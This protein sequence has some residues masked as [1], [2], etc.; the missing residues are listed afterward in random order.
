MQF[1]SNDTYNTKN[2]LSNKNLFLNRLKSP[3]KKYKRYLGSP[4]RYG[5]GKTLAVG[6]ILEYLPADIKKVVSPFFG[7]GSVEIAIAKELEVEV[8]GY[9]IFEIL[10]NYWQIQISHPE[11]LYQELLKIKPTSENYE[12]IKSILKQHWNKLDGYD[13]KLDDL[14]CA[15]YYFFNHNLSYGPGFLGWMSSIYREEKKYLA[16]IEKV[17]NFDVKNLNV[18]CNKFEETIPKHTQDFLYLDPP[19]FLA[20]DSKM[21]R[22]IYPMRNFPIHHNGFNH[23]LLS[24]LLHEHKGGFILSYNDCSWVRERYKN[25][26]IIEVSWQY[27]MGQGETRIGKNR[28]ERNYDNNYIKHSHELLIIGKK[29]ED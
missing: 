4:L 11:K 25:F 6:Y 16:L 23:L 13:G 8:I 20:G 24:Q 9:D 27:T 19:Y 3:T 7:G 10:V 17:K 28:M 5:G 29:Y 2:V 14:E 26:E 18:Y 15:T 12:N 1:D 22:G 21:F